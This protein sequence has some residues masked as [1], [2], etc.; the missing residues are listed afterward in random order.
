MKEVKIP[1]FGI[2][3]QPFCSEA[4]LSLNPDELQFPEDPASIGY[5]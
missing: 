4:G 2:N 3:V 1:L 5:C